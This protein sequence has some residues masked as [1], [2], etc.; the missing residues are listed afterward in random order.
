MTVPVAIAHAAWMPERKRTLARLLEQ[1]PHATVLSSRRREHAAIWAR[2]AWE[3]AE[4]QEGSAC[5]LNDD[6]TVCDDFPRVLD[7]MV[8]AVPGRAL[9]LHTSVPEAAKIAGRWVRC[10]WL[11]GPG[12]VLAPGTAERLLDY[13]AKVPWAYMGAPGRN[14][15]LIAIN[16][17]WSLQEPFWNC[18][19]A[20]VR[21]DTETAS[22]LGY[23]DHPLRSS[24][25]DWADADHAAAFRGD[26]TTADYWRY[27][28][29]APPFAENP[30]AKTAYL[31]A[32][33]RGLALPNPCQ[34]CWQ[35]PAIVQTGGTM[36]CGGCL[37]RATT[38]ILGNA[39]VSG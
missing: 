21:H 18:I 15:D 25:V 33:R 34:C 31:E 16:W 19:P 13:W 32:I 7:A 39:R 4:D 35:Q 38:A 29:V 11:T 30:W 5:I 14:E 8:A 17:A 28:A 6:V 2:R 36:S 9:S 26:M 23:D 20:V 10:Y 27:G 12:Y 37:A 24:C 3:W 1:V 22:S